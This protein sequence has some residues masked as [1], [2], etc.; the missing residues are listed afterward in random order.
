MPRAEAVYRDN[1]RAVTPRFIRSAAALTTE[2]RVASVYSYDCSL[3]RM[4]QSVSFDTPLQLIQIRFY[5]EG[6]SRLF[7]PLV[8]NW[9]PRMD[10][11][12]IVLR[13][14]VAP[15]SFSGVSRRRSG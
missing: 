11:L 9:N 14:R 15:F 1:R 3:R 6:K 5:S 12:K 10:F 4:L 13:A 7:R 8:K 2:A